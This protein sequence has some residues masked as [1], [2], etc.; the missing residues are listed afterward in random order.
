MVGN[1]LQSDVLGAQ[2]VGMRAVWLTN[3]ASPLGAAR[4]DA[5][6]SRLGE[7]EAALA[8]IEARA[9]LSSCPGADSLR[10]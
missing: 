4:P 2:R 6:I 10:A 9:T 7:L 3:G 8:S 5:V 1:S